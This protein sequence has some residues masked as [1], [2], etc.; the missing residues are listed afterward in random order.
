[1]KFTRDIFSRFS[2]MKLLTLIVS[3]FM[4]AQASDELREFHK[5]GEDSRNL[6]SLEPSSKVFRQAEETKVD[7]LGEKSRKLRSLGLPESQLKWRR[8]E[9]TAKKTHAQSLKDLSSMKNTKT[10]RQNQIKLPRPGVAR[11]E[12]K[13]CFG[14]GHQCQ[15]ES[16][17]C[18]G[19]R[20]KIFQCV[21]PWN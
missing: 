5:S 19:L 20:C 16:Q 14:F 11:Q 2:E 21:E 6:R 12:E 17:C 10:R 13:A 7:T 4:M 15:D 3:L 9:K 18:P 8:Q 1:M